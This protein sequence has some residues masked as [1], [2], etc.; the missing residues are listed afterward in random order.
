ML[1]G[2]LPPLL[3]HQATVTAISPAITSRVTNLK[4]HAPTL[5]GGLVTVTGA[6][7]RSASRVPWRAW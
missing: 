7:L 4:S 6:T 3:C 1:G 2:S 5:D